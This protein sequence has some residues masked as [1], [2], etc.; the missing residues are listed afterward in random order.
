[1]ARRER[2]FAQLREPI[3]HT[4][5]A[6]GVQTPSVGANRNLANSGMSAATGNSTAS[7]NRE[8][9][10]EAINSRVRNTTEPTEYRPQAVATQ[11]EQSRP[12]IKGSGQRK[13]NEPT[14]TEQ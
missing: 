9:R 5:K 2:E 14:A 7:R 6:S 12:V 10:Q 8:F 3:Q 13:K 4:P 1:M 11:A